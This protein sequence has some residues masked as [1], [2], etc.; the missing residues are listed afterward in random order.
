[1]PLGILNDKSWLSLTKDEEVID[2]ANPSMWASLPAYIFSGVLI[3]IGVF[4]ALYFGIPEALIISLVGFLLGSA[5]EIR[6]RFTWYVLTT[7]EVYVKTGIISQYPRH[8]RYDNIE[9]HEMDK[10]IVERIFGFADI[11]LATAGSDGQELL[12]SNVPDAQNFKN[13]IVS[14]IDIAHERMYANSRDEAEDSGGSRE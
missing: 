4:V 6:R 12:I 5:E 10:T 9:D 7:E 8:A 11:Y 13:E 2:E 14:Q 3:G 1:M